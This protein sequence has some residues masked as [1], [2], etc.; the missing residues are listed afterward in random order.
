MIWQPRHTWQRE[1]DLYWRGYALEGNT[2]VDFAAVH[3]DVFTEEGT[4]RLWLR[5]LNGCFA[6]VYAPRGRVRLAAV[7]SGRTIPLFYDTREP[8][9][10]DQVTPED[11]RVR[12]LTW[13]G[14]RWWQDL[15][16]LPGAH[17]LEPKIRSLEP[18][19]FL[20]SSAGAQRILNYADAPV[21]EPAIFSVPGAGRLFRETLLGALERTVALAAGRP[22]VVMLSGGF[23]SRAVLAGLHTL[24]CRSLHAFTY[25]LPDSEEYR[26]AKAVTDQLGVPHHFI[27]YR[28]PDLAE[29]VQ[30][31][32]ANY[33]EF[34]ANAQS[35]P[36]EQEWPAA[37]AASQLPEIRDGLFLL[38][39]GGDTFGGAPVP[40]HYFRLPGRRSPRGV[41]DWILHRYTRIPLQRARTLLTN[42]LPAGPFP[43]ERM[44]TDA[45]REWLIRERLAKYMFNGL[46]SYEYAGLD[47]YLP[48]W[49]QALREFWRSV[50]IDMLRRREHYRKW[51]AELLLQPAGVLLPDEPLSPPPVWRAEW[52][53][54]VWKRRP[55]AGRDPN[56]LH[57]LL[58]PALYQELEHAKHPRTINEWMGLYTTARYS[59][60]N[61]R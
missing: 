13:L 23:D 40:L 31:H 51:I 25:G 8:R 10:L 2:V 60:P 38:G 50:P 3:P 15:E 32:L 19:Q 58:L 20:W 36:Q 42:H 57:D 61:K 47:W 46:R 35:V 22:L 30:Q 29:Y 17:T 34:A 59:R 21:Q 9:L 48:L 4:A 39:L 56:G 55:A 53:P 41:H 7:D 5:R 1:G 16:Y 24:G 33:T 45:I 12:D 6:L 49:D 11:L 26:R 37:Y 18:R 44:I 14:R 28:R 43:D 54:P 52:I 27:D